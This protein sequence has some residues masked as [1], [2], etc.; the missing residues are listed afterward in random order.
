MLK[1]LD[2]YGFRGLPLQLISNYLSDRYQV[3]KIGNSFSSPKSVK[4]G[5]PQGSHLGPLLF[6][7]F[8][9][10][11]P[12]ISTLF[13]PLLFADD[14]TMCFRGS[15]PQTLMETCTSEIENLV[16]WAINNRL[17]INYRKTFYMIFTNKRNIS[18]PS[19]I[20]NG[21]II[22]EK[23]EGK[24]LGVLLDNKLKFNMHIDFI[25]KKVSKSIGILYRLREYLPNFSLRSLYYS[26]VYPYFL[27]CNLA[28]GGTFDSH[29][30]ILVKLQKRA[31][32]IISN[33]SFDSHTNNLFISNK[34]LKVQDIH[35]LQLAIY[36]FKMDSRNNFERVHIY[37]TRNRSA[38]LPSFARLTLTQ[39]SLSVSAVNF[40]NELPNDIKESRSLP[41]FKNGVKKFLLSKYIDA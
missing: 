23:L 39:N 3:T 18:I 1:K 36:M 15:N 16:S 30:D 22:Y 33:E 13:S 20:I 12:N 34:I 31:I 21:S 29:L 5:V 2:L 17:S 8:I 6:L 41:M 35:K 25:S 40:W 37:D 26:F 24:F 32:R 7:L 27:Y 11:L 10:D 38:L 19:V 4:I 9:N 14:L 28:W